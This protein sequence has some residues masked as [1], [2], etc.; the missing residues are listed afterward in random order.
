MDVQTELDLVEKAKTDIQAF[1][2]LYDY[3]LPKIFG[4]C[5]NRI[6]DRN[7]AEDITADVFLQAVKSIKKF[8]TSKGI[9]FGSWLY[10]VAHNK[11]VDAY[12]SGSKET[13]LE[14]HE[15][16][17]IDDSDVNKDITQIEMQ[18]KISIT[19][20]AIKP[21]YQEL[22]TLRFYSELSNSEIAKTLNVNPN[23]IAVLMHR[24]LKSFKKKFQETY[25]ESETFDL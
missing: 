4:Y 17:M 18:E 20:L 5:L 9:R 13:R 6:T 12:R 16:K 11:I 22:I 10:R 2:E 14:F 15:D 7:K 3:Y 8:D 23:N 1:N 21:R 19:L 24:A 25:P